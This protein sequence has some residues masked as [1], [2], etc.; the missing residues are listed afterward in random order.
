MAVVGTTTAASNDVTAVATTVVVTRSLVNVM[1]VG[2][3]AFTVTPKGADFG[4]DCFAFVSFPTYYNPNVGRGLRCAL[5]DTKGK[6][7]GERLYCSVAWDYTLQVHGP[8][9]A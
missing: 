5:Y 8:A 9:T 7:D 6:K 4:K 2:M 1:D 3:V